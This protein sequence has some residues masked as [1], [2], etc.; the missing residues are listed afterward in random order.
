MIFWFKI[1][2]PT[3]VLPGSQK[4]VCVNCGLKGK[5][6]I[7][8]EGEVMVNYG[9]RWSLMILGYE[10]DERALEFQVSCVF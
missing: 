8:V 5:G 7:M 4:F 2:F 9:E 1:P 3:I 6:A 10:R